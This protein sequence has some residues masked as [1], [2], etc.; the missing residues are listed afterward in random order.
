MTWRYEYPDEVVPKGVPP[1]QH[2]RSQID[3]IASLVGVGEDEWFVASDA[4]P[5]LQYTRSV[6]YLDD[7]EMAVLTRDGYRIRNLETTRID[8]PVN[9]IRAEIEVLPGGACRQQRGLAR[10]P[11][12]CHH[13]II[14]GLALAAGVGPGGTA[15]GGAKGYGR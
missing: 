4:S 8:K 2:L 9:Q 11:P 10:G 6:V 1:M 7:G 13:D 3:R 5:L 14:G 12:D 15:A